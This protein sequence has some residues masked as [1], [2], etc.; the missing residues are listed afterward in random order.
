M[1]DHRHLLIECYLGE[2]APPR[3][4]RRWQRQD[5]RWKRKFRPLTTTIWACFITGILVGFVAEIAFDWGGDHNR[6]M[7]LT[8]D[9]LLSMAIGLL[10]LY[11]WRT[12]ERFEGLLLRRYERWRTRA[13]SSAHGRASTDEYEAGHLRTLYAERAR[14]WRWRVDH[15]LDIE[16]QS[17][18]ISRDPTCRLLLHACLAALVVA[19]LVDDLMEVHDK[20]LLVLRV[21]GVIV[22]GLVV[23]S[24]VLSKR[25]RRQIHQAINGCHCPACGYDLEAVSVERTPQHCSECGIAWPFLMPPVYTARDLAGEKRSY[26]FRVESS[27]APPGPVQPGD[28]NSA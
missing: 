27:G 2:L 4:R 11:K 26:L 13:I 15:P 12:R 8:G 18:V 21:P 24:V 28:A 23:W 19:A 20:S 3:M 17:T 9:S 16:R 5:R 25:L 1:R 6:S 14:F 7:K 22:L 10:L